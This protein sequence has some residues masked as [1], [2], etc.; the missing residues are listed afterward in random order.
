MTD[1]TEALERFVGTWDILTVWQGRSLRG[2]WASFEWI[3]GGAF[4]RLRSDAEPDS[5]LAQTWGE[6]APFPITAVIGA[7]DPSGTYGYQY[8]DG[9]S[10]HRVYEMTLEGREWRTRGVAGP[11]FHQRSIGVFSEDGDRIDMRYE[12]SADGES[13]ELDFEVTYVRR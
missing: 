10:V 5:E 13:W 8:A 12:R 9:R 11:E 4:L 7:D 1:T 3:E 2:A 6:A